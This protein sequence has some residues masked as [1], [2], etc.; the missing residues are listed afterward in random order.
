MAAEHRG[1]DEP[2]AD[3]APLAIRDETETPE[4]H[5]QLYAWG[6]VVDTD[7]CSLPPRS[8]TLDGKAGEGAVRDDDTAASKEDPD[9]DHGEVLFHPGLDV[10]F[11]REEPPPRLAVAIGPVRAHFLGHL[12]DQLVGELGLAPGAVEPEL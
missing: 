5:L 11:F 2:V 8:T 10:L 6:W 7:R 9:L 4:V 3:P 1:E 12:A